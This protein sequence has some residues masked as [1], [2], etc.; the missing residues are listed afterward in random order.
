[1]FFYVSVVQLNSVSRYHSVILA[2]RR[3][4]QP[5]YSNKWLCKSKDGSGTTNP[6]L[7]IG[8]IGYTLSFAIKRI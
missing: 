3:E 2:I 8:K 5:S 4:I 1:M 6:S 7:T